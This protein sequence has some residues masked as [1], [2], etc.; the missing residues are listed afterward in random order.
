MQKGTSHINDTSLSMRKYSLSNNYFSDGIQRGLL[1]GMFSND[2][3]MGE[4]RVF[5]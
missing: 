4:I 5:A 3:A 2:R 1:V